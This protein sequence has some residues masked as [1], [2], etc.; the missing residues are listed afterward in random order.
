MVDQ[1][2]ECT[3]PTSPTTRLGPPP[4]KKIVK[5]KKRNPNMD[6]SEDP[7][8]LAHNGWLVYPT[9]GW[10]MWQV[11]MFIGVTSTNFG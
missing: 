11:T 8:H 4:K 3:D 2:D 1:G 9:L 6:I 7:N 5:G 10:I